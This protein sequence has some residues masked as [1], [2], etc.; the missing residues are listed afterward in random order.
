M[1]GSFFVDDLPTQRGGLSFLRQGVHSFLHKTAW[2][3]YC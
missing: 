3:F 1:F 2:Y